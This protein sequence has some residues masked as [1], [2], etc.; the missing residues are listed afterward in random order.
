VLFSD[1]SVTRAAVPVPSAA[2]LRRFAVQWMADDS[3]EL[4]SYEDGADFGTPGHVWA[5]N[6]V[7]PQGG[8]LVNLGDPALDLPMMAQ[9]YTWPA[10]AAHRAE[11]TIEAP[12]TA[13]TCARELLGETIL[14]DKGAVTVTDLTLAMPDCDAQGD[15]LVLNNLLP[16]TTL[17]AA[18]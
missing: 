14:A 16:D 2:D 10:D 18:N 17:A 6:P 8:Y 1:A 11:V 13:R 15:I 5:Q 4:H 7:S 9:V 12:V 3:F